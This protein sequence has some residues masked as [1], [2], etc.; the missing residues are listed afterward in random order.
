MVNPEVAERIVSALDIEPNELIVEIGPGKGALTGV[1]AARASY[2]LLVERD[3]SLAQQMT[4][5]F[6]NQPQVHVQIGDA[7]NLDPARFN[8][9]ELPTRYKVIGNMP[10]Y[11]ATKIIRGLLELTQPPTTIVATL[12]REV[13]ERMGARIG[14]MSFLSLLIQSRARVT[15]LFDI[16]PSEFS[17][18]PKVV[19]SVIT[20]TP[21]A[22]QRLDLAP[23]GLIW[24]LAVASFHSPRKMLQNSISAGMRTDKALVEEVMVGAG[25][26]MGK[27][28]ADLS[29]AEWTSLSQTW[30]KT[31]NNRV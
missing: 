21:L 14:R 4:H 25:I 18:P 22:R 11:A 1:L 8:A 7:R 23:G 9:T 15:K 13:A 31:V 24:H 29:L 16:A 10:Y 19:S 3:A 6:S 17:P 30:A 26:D 27:R 2:L 20:I 12:Q 5:Q 28:P